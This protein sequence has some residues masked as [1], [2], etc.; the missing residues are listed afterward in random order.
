[1]LQSCQSINQLFDGAMLTVV[2]SIPRIWNLDAILQK[3]RTSF[4]GERTLTISGLGLRVQV[5]FALSDVFKKV[6]KIEGRLDLA[7]VKRN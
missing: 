3:L 5:V 7:A 4:D 1:V 2:V 6:G